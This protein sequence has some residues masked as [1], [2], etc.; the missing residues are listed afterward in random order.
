MRVHFFLAKINTSSAARLTQQPLRRKC[1]AVRDNAN[2]MQP[3]PGGKQMIS[4]KF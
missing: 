4:F 1:L 3:N 2:L